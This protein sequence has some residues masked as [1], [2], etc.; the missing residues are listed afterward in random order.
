MKKIIENLYIG[1]V[2]NIPFAEQWGYSILGACKEPLHRQHAKLQGASEEGYV[3]RAMP[4]DEPEY[5]FAER[6]HALYLN[7]IDA[8]EAK[9]IPDECINKAL[10]FIDKEIADN[11]DVLIVCN[12]GESRSPS[13]A[14]MYLI[15]KWLFDSFLWWSFE[16]VLNVFL[17]FYD[18][19]N[20][21]NG[22]K[23][24]VKNFWE[25]YCNKRIKQLYGE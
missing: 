4:K 12:K 14:F 22:M 15:E 7:L 21:S 18:C 11:R 13:I 8:R 1:T 25:K 19:Y 3:G 24:Y 20:P 5:L 23:E 2:E 17:I 9:Y 6:D 16:S 10:D